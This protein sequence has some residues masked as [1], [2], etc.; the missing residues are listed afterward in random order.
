MG[1][2]VSLTFISIGAILAFATRFTLTGIDVRMIGWILLL[3]GLANLAF[4]LMYTRP[5]R[6][7]QIAEVAEEPVYIVNPDEPEAPVHPDELTPHVHAGE[8]VPHVHPQSEP[9]A[10]PQPG[11]H[12][13]P[14]AVQ[15]VDPRARTEASVPVEDQG[16]PTAPHGRRLIRRRLG[17]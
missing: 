5:R 8:P 12:V 7:A 10:R 13:P 11:S 15:H 2:G 16:D 3:V 9:A 14:E 17:S 4:T 6:R 1:L